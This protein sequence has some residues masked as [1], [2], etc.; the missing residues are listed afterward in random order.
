M[1]T[2]EFKLSLKQSQQAQVDDWLN[3]QRW[4]WNR[5]LELLQKFETNFVWDKINKSWVSRCSVPWQYYRDKSSSQ[6]VSFC[7]LPWTYYRRGKQLIPFCRLAERHN[8][9]PQD[10]QSSQI[11]SPT[12]F[13]LLYYFAQKNHP[14]KPWFSKVPSKFV[15]G[16]LKSLTDAW[17]EY[18]S[19][20]RHCP[21]YKRYQDKLKTLINNNVKSLK[22]SGKRITLPKLGKVSVKTLDKRWD[23]SVPIS[24]LKIIKEASGYYLQLTGDMPIDKKPLLSDK[25][26]GL[27]TGGEF[28]YTTDSGKAILPPLHYRKI[29]KRLKRLQRQ[30]SRRQLGSR[31]QQQ[32]YQQI[33]RLYERSRRLTRAFNHKLSTYLVREYGAIAVNEKPGSN[34]ASTEISKAMTA[35]APGQLLTLIEQKAQ[36]AERE[37]V[38]VPNQS[39]PGEQQAA[40]K[41]VYTTAKTSFARNYR[42]W[43][44]KITPEE[45][46]VTLNQEVPPGTPPRD[47]G[48]TFKSS[49]AKTKRRGLVDAPESTEALLAS[50][51]Q[52]AENLAWDGD[53]LSCATS[54]SLKETES[55]LVN[56]SHQ[57]SSKPHQLVHRYSSAQPDS[58]KQSGRKKRQS[59]VEN[60]ESASYRG[61]KLTDATRR[62]DCRG[63]KDN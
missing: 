62:E 27:V 20:E 56:P 36:V 2:I 54:P 7:R 37:F 53:I 60:D 14:D 40:A 12:L 61:C 30:A 1:R 38:E 44:W 5:G 11:Q 59:V 35:N 46:T 24:T 15:A 42:P 22:V 9:L 32:T 19:G 55:K 10:Y 8:H 33:A 48:T 31:N 41:A 17:Q 43:G 25:A 47:A 4:V 49:P 6:L 29:E 28:V 3:V 18:K 57:E 51:Q 50:N 16:T 13:G 21:R 39:L 58:E 45:S 52:Q 63:V 26:I 23:S 34:R